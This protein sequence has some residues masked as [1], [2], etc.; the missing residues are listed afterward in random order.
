MLPG[1]ISNYSSHVSCYFCLAGFE[2]S[3]FF[4]LSSVRWPARFSSCPS[5]LSFF[6]AQAVS[7]PTSGKVLATI[8]PCAS[9]TGSSSSRAFPEVHEDLSCWSSVSLSHHRHLCSCCPGL[10]H[11]P[12]PIKSIQ[13]MISDILFFTSKF[14]S[15]LYIFCPLRRCPVISFVLNTF[16]FPSLSALL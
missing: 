16:S 9:P 8:L 3:F 11:L 4:W 7:F 15:L 2:I 14:P 13:Q 10:C 5:C 1:K 12:S 6:S